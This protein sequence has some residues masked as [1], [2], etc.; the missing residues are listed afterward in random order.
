MN[1]RVAILS[2]AATFFLCGCDAL[3]IGKL[4]DSI[5]RI[6]DT[7][8]DAIG[9]K[10]LLSKRIKELTTGMRE[11]LVA[12]GAK[13]TE[14]AVIKFAIARED[15][16]RD[17]LSLTQKIFG[18]TRILMREFEGAGVSIPLQFVE[19]LQ[20]MRGEVRRDL[21]NVIAP[22]NLIYTE[23]DVPL[24]YDG[25]NW[26]L[27]PEGYQTVWFAIKDAKFLKLKIGNKLFAPQEV[28]AGSVRYRIPIEASDDRQIKVPGTN[29]TAARFSP[30]G[31][32]CETA[33]AMACEKVAGK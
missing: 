1:L 28:R 29:G 24:D 18:D 19:S 12:A 6:G 11:E 8:K 25:V 16:I 2:L 3:Q 31:A 30:C 9:D 15:T 7:F 27:R 32:Q 21:A 17:I 14:D 22:L 4:A 20:N 13:V 5:D 26:S 33:H 10:G 23:R